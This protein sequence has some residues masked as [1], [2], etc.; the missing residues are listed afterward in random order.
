MIFLKPP[1][2]YPA[3]DGWEG[4]R[5]SG[6]PEDLPMTIVLFELREKVRELMTQFLLFFCKKIEYEIIRVM[7]WWK[8][9]YACFI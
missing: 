4:F 5:E 9:L 8:R 3:I 6:E 7:E 2:H 1:C